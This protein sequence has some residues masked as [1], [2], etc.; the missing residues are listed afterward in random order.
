MM[1]VC[2]HVCVF[3]PVCS[4]DGRWA[5]FLPVVSVVGFI[6]ALAL[7]ISIADGVLVSVPLVVGYIPLFIV[8]GLWLLLPAAGMHLY[9]TRQGP[10]A[11][12]FDPPQPFVGLTVVR[13]SF[14]LLLCGWLS[15]GAAC[16][17]RWLDFFPR[18]FVLLRSV[19]ALSR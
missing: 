5:A 16:C 15:A 1:L 18:C 11:V 13:A 9:C 10:W 14:V 2:V 12:S 8:A 17:F 7:C 4:A 19:C 3:V 6:I